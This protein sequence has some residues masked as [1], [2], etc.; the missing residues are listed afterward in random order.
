[1]GSVKPGDEAVKMIVARVGA[2]TAAAA[3]AAGCVNTSPWM[4]KGQKRAEIWFEGSALL[5]T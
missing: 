1:M 4:L 2:P 3:A 5:A